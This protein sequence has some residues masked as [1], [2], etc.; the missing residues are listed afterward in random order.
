MINSYSRSYARGIQNPREA[1]KKVAAR[2]GKSWEQKSAVAARVENEKYFELT[3]GACKGTV[4][5]CVHTLSSRCVKHPREL[6]LSALAFKMLDAL[7]DSLSSN[8]EGF[9]PS[10]HAETEKEATLSPAR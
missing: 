5:P 6:A 10:A 4:A 9:I 7:N 1:R 3:R 8:L 2:E